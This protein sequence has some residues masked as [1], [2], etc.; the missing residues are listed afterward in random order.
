MDLPESTDAVVFDC[1][2]LL[3]DTET[4]W[5]RAE[6]AIFAEHGHGV[7]AARAAG[8][9]VIGIP[10]LPGVPLDTD[11]VFAA[12]TDPA[13]TRRGATVAGPPLTSHGISAAM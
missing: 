8:L 11:I 4:G 1:D 3:V 9:Y 2:G 10:S 12:L 7:A 5:T 13:L 6:T